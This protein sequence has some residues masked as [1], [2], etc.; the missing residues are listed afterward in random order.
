ML[1]CVVV[2]ARGNT[3]CRGVS[4]RFAIFFINSLAAITCVFVCVYKREREREKESKKERAK[5]RERE[6][7]REGEK[8]RERERER[9]CARASATKKE[10]D[11]VRKI[12]RDFAP[13]VCVR[14]GVYMCM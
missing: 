2:P 6:K 12:F 14:M 10:S 5:E 7:E 3:W 1:Q 11:Q 4:L 9:K 13:A 8:E